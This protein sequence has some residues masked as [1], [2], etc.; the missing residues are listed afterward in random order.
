MKQKI[1]LV[2]CILLIANVGT[3]LAEKTSPT[4]R[5]MITQSQ[6]VQT[7]PLKQLALVIGNNNYDIAPLKNAVNDATKI[8]TV[9]EQQG[10]EVIREINLTYGDMLEALGKF[11]KL[12]AERSDVGLF[13]YAGHG[14]QIKG[15]NFL[16][17]TNNQEMRRE[18][19][20]ENKAVKVE[21]I[22]GRMGETGVKFKVIVID[23]CRDNPFKFVA[24]R[25]RSMSMTRGLA[26]MR[27]ATGTIL[28]F[29]TDPGSVASD[30][31][32]EGQGLYTK[33]LVEALKT[34][35]LPIQEVFQ[36][37]RDK[38]DA[39]SHGKQRPW[40]NVSL[41]GRYCFGGCIDPKEEIE[42]LKQLLAEKTAKE[43]VEIERK[44]KADEERLAE[45]ERKRKAAEEATEIERKR[46]A[47]EEAAE[48]QDNPTVPV[49]PIAPVPEATVTEPMPQPQ[50]PT[51]TTSRGTIPVIGF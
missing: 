28:A 41:G 8:A 48:P 47:A 12:L 27:A 5:A 11:E 18:A 31:D 51:E 26:E 39:E 21:D 1:L 6:P 33:H 23:A 25:S 43:A 30:G 29:A 50:P 24:T 20:V 10:F 32:E 38:V 16:I 22:M 3:T 19:D 17:P 15:E 45:I 35:H 4:N 40:T 36:Q 37:V 42:R 13:F 44:R 9:L 7:Q 14:V 2:I 34:P 49:D 46:K